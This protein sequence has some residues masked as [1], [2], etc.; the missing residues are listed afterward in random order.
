MGF[1]QGLQVGHIEEQ[2]RI[3]IVRLDMI[4]LGSED[5]MIELQTVR[6]P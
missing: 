6:T 3:T 5:M 2:H 4:H 1:T